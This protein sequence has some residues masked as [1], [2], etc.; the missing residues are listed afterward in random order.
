VS[1][2]TFGWSDPRGTFGGG[3]MAVA[4]PW[5]GAPYISHEILQKVGT[6]RDYC[7]MVGWELEE[8]HL[9][10]DDVIEDDKIGVLKIA[11]VGEVVPDFGIRVS[12]EEFYV[13]RQPKF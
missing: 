5:G 4:G 7:V 10:K 6:L 2:Y 11:P 3:D 13:I 9:G 8:V 1:R 12:E